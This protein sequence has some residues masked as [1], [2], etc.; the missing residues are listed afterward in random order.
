MS[1]ALTNAR[2]VVLTIA[3]RRSPTPLGGTVLNLTNGS[4]TSM[5]SDGEE[6]SI[7]PPSLLCHVTSL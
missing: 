5:T 4:D 7:L 2:D 3:S 6:V 1:S